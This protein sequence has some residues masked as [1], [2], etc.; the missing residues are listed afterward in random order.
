MNLAWHPKY[1]YSD[2]GFPH[3]ETCRP[4]GC[5]YVDFQ[6]RIWGMNTL[7]LR[8]LGAN[9]EWTIPFC[10]RVEFGSY[11]EAALQFSRKYT[12]LSLFNANDRALEKI[13]CIFR[14]HD[15][16]MDR[17][18]AFEDGFGR[19]GL[20][21]KKECISILHCLNLRKCR[22]CDLVE[23]KWSFRS[24]WDHNQGT[25]LGLEMRVGAFC[26]KECFLKFE[27]SEEKRLRQQIKESEHLKEET[28]WLRK[29]KQLLKALK[30][31][32]REG[33]QS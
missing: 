6:A 27:V 17:L 13:Q 8:V 4:K 28:E 7:Q 14:A 1:D 32:L 21:C 5:R 3:L 26:S 15:I 19:P 33:L 11:K 31:H 12:G 20:V 18:L 23:T 2:I 25:G 24:K 22:G 10:W 9:Y 29:N 16:Y 30:T